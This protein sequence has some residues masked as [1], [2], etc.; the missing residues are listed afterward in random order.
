[1]RQM[2]CWLLIAEMQIAEVE[3]ATYIVEIL[4]QLVFSIEI[5]SIVSIAMI[6]SEKS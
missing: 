3:I 1:M 5:D 6:D 2:K 4:V